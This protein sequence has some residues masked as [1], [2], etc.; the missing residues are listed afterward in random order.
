MFD[1]EIFKNYLLNY[2][3]NFFPKWWKDEKY[4]CEMVKNF[5]E[6]WDLNSKNFSEMLSRSLAKTYNLL[7]GGHYLP[8]SVIENVFAKNEPETVR[9]MFSQLFDEKIDV[10]ARI[11]NFKSESAKLFEKYGNPLHL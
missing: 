8:R 4:K 5:Q 6:N 9:K 2:K 10:W 11:D 7:A 1:G 3:K